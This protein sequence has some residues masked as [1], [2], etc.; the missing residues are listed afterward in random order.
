ML[1]SR[2]RSKME[3]TWTMKGGGKRKKIMKND[4]QK[5]CI[6]K[7]EEVKENSR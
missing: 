6:L 4:D 2:G 5:L 3:L 7:V 1:G